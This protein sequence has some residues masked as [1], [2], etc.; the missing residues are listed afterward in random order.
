ME[1][2]PNKKLIPD[3]PEWFRIGK[4]ACQVIGKLTSAK[5]LAFYLRHPEAFIR[6]LAIRRT[7]VLLLSDAVPLLA[8]ILDDPLENE[9]NLDE[10][11]WAIKRIVRNRGLA[12]FSK[13][14]HTERYDGTEPPAS[15]YGVQIKETE[16]M[17]NP[18]VANRSNLE[19]LP[20]DEILLRI[21]MDENKVRIDFSMLPWV[22]K[23]IRYLLQELIQV[24]FKGLNL[25]AKFFVHI[26]KK[27]F[28]AM[29]SGVA[30]GLLSIKNRRIERNERQTTSETPQK[31]FSHGLDQVQNHI[32]VAASS[33]VDTSEKGVLWIGLEDGSTSIKKSI[34]QILTPAI[35]MAT[36][37]VGVG[38]PR[39]NSLRVTDIHRTQ[40][41]DLNHCKKPYGSWKKKKRGHS[42][43]KLLFYPVRLVKQHWVFTLVVLLTFYGMLGFN[44]LGRR[45]V[46]Q[47][48]PTALHANDRMVTIV[49]TSLRQF[50]QVPTTTLDQENSQAKQSEESRHTATNVDATA[51]TKESLD[52]Y[53]I[54]APKGLYLREMPSSSGLKVV[55]MPHATT[56][57]VLDEEKTDELGQR[58]RLA[59][60]NGK[61]GWAMEKWISP[62]NE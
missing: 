5:D 2:S 16:T 51:T 57:T 15:R 60:Y 28:H 62:L 55:L 36:A 26:L 8:K 43:F 53:L 37:T 49:Q 47:I 42:M 38:P 33:A 1:K 31:I 13:T 12:W 20:D 10:A 7:A 46:N 50:F 54:T 58:W 24:L 35:V 17:Q 30:Q 4:D 6:L 27:S 19:I 45:F 14:A 18:A 41:S 21:Q 22:K 61:T 25:L 39:Q 56:L 34:P 44:Q 9:Q 59:Q 3:E 48:N 52:R 23:N 11:A 29:G 40:F 32:D